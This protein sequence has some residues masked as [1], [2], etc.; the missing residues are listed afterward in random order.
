[1][2][3]VRVPAPR[4]VSIVSLVVALVAVVTAAAVVAV[5]LL[6]GGSTTPGSFAGENPQT[7]AKKLAVDV[8][9]YDYRTLDAGTQHVLAET[10]GDAK[11][12]YARTSAQLHDTILKQQASATAAAVGTGL[13][14]GGGNKAVVLVALRQHFA[15]ASGARDDKAA[16]QLT[17][18]RAATS[19][20]WLVSVIQPL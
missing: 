8:T 16:V 14:S 12:S 11:A 4:T 17:L 19:A 7:T 20:P 10:T 13:V 1:V 2:Q 9:T 15:S 6:R 5:T 18:T 3:T